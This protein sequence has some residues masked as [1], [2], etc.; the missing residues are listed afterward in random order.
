[1]S[2]GNGGSVGAAS[3]RSIDSDNPI[4][5]DQWVHLAATVRGPTDM[6]LYV[7]GTPVTATFSGTGG[8]ILHSPAPARIGSYS[9][10]AANTPWAGMLDE[11]R[12]YNCSLDA[13]SVSALYQQP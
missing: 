8:P 13:A 2:Y 4:P 6:T 3:R 7:N 11:M 10:I 5:L 1:M 9:L 12:I